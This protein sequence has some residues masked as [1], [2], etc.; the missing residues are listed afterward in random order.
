MNRRAGVFGISLILTRIPTISLVVLSIAYR[1]ATW[2]F[3]TRQPM[4]LHDYD[5]L[6][7]VLAFDEGR[8]IKLS[9]KYQG[10][11]KKSKGD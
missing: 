9:P 1:T 11:K 10:G 3:G 7:A 4:V 8:I 6:A 5:G 2:P